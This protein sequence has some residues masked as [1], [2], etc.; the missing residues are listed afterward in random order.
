MRRESFLQ[1]AAAIGQFLP[2]AVVAESSGKPPLTSHPPQVSAAE[3][4]S[5]QLF[6][7]EEQY[8][9]GQGIRDAVGDD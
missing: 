2:S 5:V 6:Q 8:H 3:P 7:A 1:T 9:H 4:G